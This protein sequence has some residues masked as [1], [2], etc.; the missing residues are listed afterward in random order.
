MFPHLLKN[1]LLR[2]K[3]CFVLL[4]RILRRKGTWWHKRES[5]PRLLPN[6]CNITHNMT[7]VAP[8]EQP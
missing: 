5:H 6:W 4:F 8:S 7:F 1:S 3:T 2:W